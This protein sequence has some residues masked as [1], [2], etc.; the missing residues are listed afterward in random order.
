MMTNGKFITLEG[1]EGAGKTTVLEIVYAHLASYQIEV[2][3]THEPGGTVVAEKIRDL[4][5][6]PNSTETIQSE[7]ELLMLFAGRAQHLS[8]CILPALQAGKWVVSDRFID[9]SYAY[10]GGGRGT[11]REHIKLLDQWIVGPCYPDLTLL[12]DV[13]PEVGHMRMAKRGAVKDRIEAEKNDFFA[14][15]REVYLQRAQHDAKR[16]KVI[17]A[18]TGLAEVKA[19]VY[20]ELDAFIGQLRH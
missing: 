6:H 20:R 18:N 3:L 2:V 14:R 13:T 10:Q 7:T 4:L 1:I 11:K 5:L 19:Q 9:A 8:Q 12:L 15:V 17:D 16:I